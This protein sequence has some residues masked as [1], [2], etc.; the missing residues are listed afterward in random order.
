MCN[1]IHIK[2]ID[3]YVCSFEYESIYFL[4]TVLLQSAY[5]TT[6][7]IIH[8]S[9]LYLINLLYICA[10]TQIENK[11]NR[12]C[13]LWR[14]TDSSASSKRFQ[15]GRRTKICDR[16][17]ERVQKSHFKHFS[18]QLATC[19]RDCFGIAMV[20]SSLW[21]LTPVFPNVQLFADRKIS[22]YLKTKTREKAA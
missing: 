1:N 15:M 13:E 12:A 8:V 20:C 22:N 16:F 9:L 5:K 7:Y 19:S 4:C 11:Q 17:W 6:V 14:R 3:Q 21:T 18:G 10:S 2:F